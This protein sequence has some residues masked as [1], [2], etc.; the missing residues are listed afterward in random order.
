MKINENI[1]LLEEKY[2]PQTIDDI[3]LPKS[4]REKFRSYIKNDNL[5]NILLISD[6]PGLGKTT[7]VKILVNEMDSETKWINASKDN[8]VDTIR[9]MVENFCSS[10]SYN[11]KKK[12]VV[13]DESDS[14]TIGTKTAPG[15]QE[16]LRG[17]IETYNTSSRFILTANYEDRFIAP[18]LD[19]LTI[20]N[21][22]DI[23]QQNKS[24]VG[25]Q[26]LQRLK[27]ILENE[28]I[29]YKESDVKNII[30]ENFPSMRAMTVAIE[31]N[32]INKVLTVSSSN[33]IH[34]YDEL[35]KLVQSK[36]FGKVRSQ[37]MTLSSITNFYTWFWKNMEK[38]IEPK[39]MPGI[40]I[41]L[42]QAQDMNSRAKN[43][44]I[45][46]MMLLTKIMK[47]I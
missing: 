15:S 25:A 19:R 27:F 33:I 30:M 36:E 18:L 9:Y 14:L 11:T 16:I 31:R 3:I 47:V 13:M 40:I 43:K 10:G 32:T 41:E 6:T 21:F 29:E 20:F 4:I 28:G 24:E 34:E 7:L 22:D 37:I 35:M 1:D 45:T 2:R 38:Y 12:M 26:M 17:T 39:Q 44:Q 46:L 8:G 5:P 23:M 42:A